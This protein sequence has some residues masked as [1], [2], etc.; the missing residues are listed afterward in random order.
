MNIKCIRREFGNL[1]LLHGL[2]LGLA[3]ILLLPGCSSSVSTTPPSQDGPSAGTSSPSMPTSLEIKV[4]KQGNVGESTE[5]LLTVG[6]IYDAGNVTPRFEFKCKR[7]SENYLS[8]IKEEIISSQ[9]MNIETRYNSVIELKARQN[10][11]FNYTVTFPFEGVWEVTVSIYNSSGKFITGNGLDLMVKNN[12]T[13]IYDSN[14]P[15]WMMDYAPPVHTLY[16]APYDI[17]FDMNQPPKLNEISELSWTIT[18]IEDFEE[19]EIWIA[20]IRMEPYTLLSKTLD[21][22]LLVT[23]GELNWKGPIKAG[24]DVTSSAKIVFPEEGDWILR[25]WLKTPQNTKAPAE[26]YLHVGKDAGR[27]GWAEPH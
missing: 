6:S 23:T 7:L 11:S 19:I 2:L 10:I 5:L 17:V 25:L 22:K 15:A 4:A 21:S 13:G 14:N 16:K 18:A 26:I 24:S 3:L 27:W 12:K 9:Q 8:Y 20:Y 1:K